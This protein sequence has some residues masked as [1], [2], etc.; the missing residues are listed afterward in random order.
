[1]SGARKNLACYSFECKFHS[2]HFKMNCTSTC[3]LP[4]VVIING[5]CTDYDLEE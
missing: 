4:E 3:S 5:I 1:M 2:V